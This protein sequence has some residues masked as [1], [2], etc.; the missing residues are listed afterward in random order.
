LLH[1][2]VIDSFTASKSRRSIQY[3]THDCVATFR[4]V[5]KAFFRPYVQNNFE[6][7]YTPA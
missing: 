6:S 2:V 5:V 1:G 3:L 7:T 4:G